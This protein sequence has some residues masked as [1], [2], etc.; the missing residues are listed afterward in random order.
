MTGHLFSLFGTSAS[1]Q[2][3]E[4][5]TIEPAV[6]AGESEFLA[7]FSGILSKILMKVLA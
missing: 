4:I 5:P 3:E 7:N 2:R 1:K 6:M